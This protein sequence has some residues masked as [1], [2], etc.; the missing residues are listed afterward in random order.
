MKA[1]APPPGAAAPAK[2]RLPLLLALLGGVVVLA[3]LSFW[4]SGETAPIVPLK[5]SGRASSGGAA[6]A[7]P[8]SVP[9]L[10]LAADRG[11][12]RGD[13]K[14]DVFRF[15]NSP[16]PT[17][18]RIPPPPTPVVL[19]DWPSLPTPVPTATPIVP[20]ALPFKAIGK[21]GPRDGPIVTLES[22]GRLINV[23][24]GDVVEGRFIV[25]RINRES[26]DFAFTDLP[27][28]ITRRLP[29]PLP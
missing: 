27:P 7:D 10:E 28:D 4:P 12:T 22:G 11:A 2:S 18:T 16:T 21:F 19:Y 20:P 9:T 23:R 26:V 6:P 15:Y 3:L 5:G 8:A 29:I 13:V 24:E 14:R 1:P 25:Q 17:P